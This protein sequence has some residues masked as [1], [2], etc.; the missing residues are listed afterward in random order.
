MAEEE[1]YYRYEPHVKK[2]AVLLYDGKHKLHMLTS[3]HT[4]HAPL[5]QAHTIV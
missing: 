4:H 1:D 3:A 5:P 2:K